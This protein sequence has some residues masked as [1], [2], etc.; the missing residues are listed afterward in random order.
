[1]NDWTDQETFFIK[2][3]EE[4]SKLVNKDGKVVHTTQVAAITNIEP[5]IE[6]SKNDQDSI[7][8]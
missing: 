1:M 7:P 3:M 2:K 5:Q 6:A 8:F 4:F